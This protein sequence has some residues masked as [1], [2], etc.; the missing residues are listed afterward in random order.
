MGCCKKRLEFSSKSPNICI[1]VF[2]QRK[3]K[4]S[5]PAKFGQCLIHTFVDEP[6]QDRKI[7]LI[8][9]SQ[10]RKKKNYFS[11]IPSKRTLASLSI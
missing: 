9:Q 4:E 1:F 3:V 6:A 5:K 2:P 8:L 11:R 7:N 10:K